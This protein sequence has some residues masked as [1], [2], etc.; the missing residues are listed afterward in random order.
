[1]PTAQVCRAKLERPQAG[2]AF[3]RFNSTLQHQHSKALTANMRMRF[4]A[5]ADGRCQFWRKS[6]Q[7][8]LPFLRLPADG[9]AQGVRTA[10][11]SESSCASKFLDSADVEPFVTARLAYVWRK[12]GKIRSSKPAFPAHSKNQR[13]R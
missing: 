1:M 6:E 7:G 8:P 13:S 2:I 5:F 9:P 3:R 12:A 11:S 10:W 4:R